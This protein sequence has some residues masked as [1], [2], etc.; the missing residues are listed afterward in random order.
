MFWKFFNFYIIEF[1]NSNF[2]YTDKLI[3][4][5]DLIFFLLSTNNIISIFW[6]N[7]EFFKLKVK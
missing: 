2:F 6:K 1:F 4:I 3:L 5:L 7:S